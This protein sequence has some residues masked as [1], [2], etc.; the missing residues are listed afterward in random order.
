MKDK[1][2][3]NPIFFVTNIN[4]LKLKDNIVEIEKRM[5]YNHFRKKQERKIMNCYDFDKTIYKKD[6]AISLLFFAIKK[7]PVLFFYLFYI[8]ILSVLHKCKLLKTKTFKEKYFGFLSRFDDKEKLIDEFWEKEQKNIND[9][10][11]EQKKD[12]DVICSASPEFVIKPIMK[13]INPESKV[14]A[15]N[16]DSETFKIEGENL[17]GEQK[18][19]LLESKGFVHFDA[20][21]TDSL[22]D[23]PLYDMSDKKYFVVN[24]KVYEFGKQKLS[25]KLKIKYVLKQLRL[26]QY[27]KNGLIFLPLI[28]SGLL[29]NVAS[30]VSAIWGFVAFSLAASIVYVVNDL[31][32]A[33]KDRNHSKKRKRPI[34]AYMIKP[35]E[36]ILMVIVLAALVSLIFIFCLSSNVL[37]IIILALYIVINLLYSFWLKKVPIVDVFIL[38]FCYVVR[39]YFG[40][41]IIGVRVSKWLYLTIICASLYMGYGKRRG[42]CKNEEGKETRDVIE[43]YT[44]NFLDKNI[45]LCLTMCLVF[46]SLWAVDYRAIT[47]AHINS[48]MFLITIPMVMFIL[49]RYSLDIEKSKNSGDPIDVLLKDGVLVLSAIIFLVFIIIAIYVPIE[50]VL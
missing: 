2:R 23:F 49:M 31:F 14:F 26:K 15:T 30:L 48:V 34:A 3:G 42:E 21:Y 11:L 13:K 5:C 27:I 20:S 41:S 37:A 12:T 50:S 36:A 10:Y 8:A 35:Y 7:K 39:V 9:W 38:A 24:G 6:S 29:T 46:Y 43:K 28:F 40:A 45:Y 1:N 33:K 22:S 4:I 19:I 32:D 47:S 18:R 16:M 25:A 44:Y 17:K